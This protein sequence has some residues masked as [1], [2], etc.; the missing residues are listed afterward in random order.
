MTAIH[1]IAVDH[2]ELALLAA[3]LKLAL[4]DARCGDGE[5]REWLAGPVARA[6]LSWLLP[7]YADL[8]RVNETL[9]SMGRGR[10]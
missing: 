9:I 6:W 10:R 3:A 5:A 8:D 1:T 2:P 7:D 4:D